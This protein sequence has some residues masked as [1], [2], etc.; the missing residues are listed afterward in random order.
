[1]SA[2]QKKQQ[3]LCALGLLSRPGV[4]NGELRVASKEIVCDV[5]VIDDSSGDEYEDGREV[6]EVNQILYFILLYFI[7]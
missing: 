4:S 7:F 5:I 3:F 2:E 1:M 6:D